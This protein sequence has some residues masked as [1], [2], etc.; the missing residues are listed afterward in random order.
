MT[1]RGPQ[2]AVS[3]E[4][5]EAYSRLPKGIQKKVR[6]FTEKFKRDPTS[7]G[8]NFETLAVRDKKVR[9]V[10]IGDDYRAI[11]IHPP[12]GDVYLCV[13][14]DHHDEAYRWVENRVFEVNPAS[15]VL[16][17]YE[18]TNVG[19]RA[20]PDDGSSP[21]A[22]A[23][24]QKHAG[25]PIKKKLLESATDEDLLLAGVPRALLASV[26]ALETDSDLDQLAPHLPEDAAEVLYSL[27]AG[28]DLVEALAAVERSTDVTTKNINVEDFAAAL[29]KPESQ[30]VFRIPSDDA[31]LERMLDAPLA[32]WRIFLHPT[33]RRL[34]TMVAN[35]PVR[36]LGGAGTGKTVVLMHR[37][38]HLASEVFRAPT[39][40]ILVT[41]F[42]KNLATDLRVNLRNLC[43]SE[44]ERIEVTHLHGFAAD[45]LRRHGIKTTILDDHHQSELFGQAV[46]ESPDAEF[47]IH[48]YRD[49][50][51]RVVQAQDISS[52][53]D[54]RIARR[55]GRGTRLDR[56]QRAG[57]WFVLQRYR[58]LRDNAGKMEW[59]DV[60]REAR[61]VIERRQ[62]Q[63]P[64]RAILVDETQDLTASDLRFIRALVPSGSNDL[65]LVGDGHQRIYGQPVR[66]S[67][68][69][70]DIRGRSRRLKVNYRTTQQIRERAVAI[71]EGCSIDDLDGERDT[72][73]GYHSLRSGPPPKIECFES[74]SEEGHAILD[75]L[76][77]WMKVGRPEEICLVA[78]TN[79]L[80]ETRY[81]PLLES[82]GVT[83]RVID[84]DSDVDQA[85]PGVR[86]ATMHRLKGLEFPR[87]IIAGVSNGT[88][89]LESALAS[90]GDSAERE[91]R[92]LQERCLLYVACT[93]ARD[94]LRIVG[95][96]R[97]SPILNSRELG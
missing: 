65:F 91:D 21:M 29:A 31:E 95:F 63:L 55:T 97:A 81:V 23:T 59:E 2:I 39:D 51:K 80:I 22:L 77:S 10:R 61:R 1:M 52:L 56:S 84:K 89:P 11:V 13:W 47:P 27:A 78:R 14:V 37:A 30:R 57:V 5:L 38:R 71:L 4:F 33:Q 68:C 19:G 86:A 17:I 70:I 82:A 93:R 12:Q 46:A 15:G 96:G 58:E 54:Y 41:T 72:N 87:V 53:D 42:T 40:R 62:L 3:K 75:Q 6:E 66:L 32:Q 60:V 69:G 25:F 74:E 18:V 24:A 64:Y 92:E 20:L 45:Q 67:S 90:A 7:R 8:I 94:E 16:Q 36:V 88:V 28:Y 83:V 49:E 9:S 43:G 85:G 73:R 79:R 50:W 34:V 26:R 76:I 44:F 35:G 48:F